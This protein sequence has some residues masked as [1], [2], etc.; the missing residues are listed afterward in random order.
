MPGVDGHPSQEELSIIDHQMAWVEG[1]PSQEELS[2]VD[3][4]LVRRFS[5]TGSSLKKQSDG[6]N[7]GV[8][9]CKMGQNVLDGC[10]EA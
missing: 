7:L 1:H 2:I 4:A 9:S 3:R 8:A 6:W 5:Q 10:S